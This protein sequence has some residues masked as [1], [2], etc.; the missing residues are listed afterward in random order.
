MP[1]ITTTTVSQ[2]REQIIASWREF[3][4]D[5]TFAN[6]TL[7]Q[8]EVESQKALDVRSRMA[9]LQ[10]QL[11]GLMIERD[12]ADETQ[13]ELFVSVSNSIRGNPEFGLNS[14]LYRSLGFVPKME[15][16]RPKRTDKKETAATPVDSPAGA[17]AV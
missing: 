9:A 15:R 14:P 8:F 13:A 5:A 3:A 4:P 2:R 10:T 17:V 7:A 12:L 16:K 11:K 6:L 1:R